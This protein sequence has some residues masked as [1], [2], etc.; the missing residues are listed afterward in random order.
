MIERFGHMNVVKFD[1]IICFA[2]VWRAVFSVC[3]FVEVIAVN[4][5][6]P[7]DNRKFCKP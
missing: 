2:W 1:A 4:I 7:I 3:K 6:L 5:F